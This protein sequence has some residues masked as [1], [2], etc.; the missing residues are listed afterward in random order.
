MVYLS[1]TPL[2]QVVDCLEGA[3]PIHLWFPVPLPVPVKLLNEKT[4]SVEL[5]VVHPEGTKAH[6]G[7]GDRDQEWDPEKS[8][9][10]LLA[11]GRRQNPG[12]G[13]QGITMDHNCD[14]AVLGKVCPGKVPCQKC[15]GA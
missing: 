13:R 6:T 7:A 4:E 8:M 12:S 1:D 2:P 11:H 15:L 5:F 9:D 14:A 3:T 10:G